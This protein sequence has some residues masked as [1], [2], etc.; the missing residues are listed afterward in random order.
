MKH[1][2]FLFPC[3]QARLWAFVHFVSV[4]LL[5]KKLHY[6]RKIKKNSDDFGSGACSGG[7]TVVS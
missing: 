3:C 2:I 6:E 1:K 4:S 5:I 7:R